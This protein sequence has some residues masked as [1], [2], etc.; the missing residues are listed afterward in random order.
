[1]ETPSAAVEARKASDIHSNQLQRTEATSKHA[2]DKAH[3]QESG[4]TLTLF[5]DGSHGNGGTRESKVTE[6]VHSPSLET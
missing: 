3:V 4:A 1:V 6:E 5:G 2:L